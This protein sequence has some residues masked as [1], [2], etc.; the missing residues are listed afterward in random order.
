M[1]SD[2]E[3]E[4]G[5]AK[6]DWFLEHGSIQ[7]ELMKLKKEAL[8]SK[9]EEI[10][11]KEVSNGD[12]SSEAPSGE[13]T[14]NGPV[15][16]GGPGQDPSEQ[17]DGCHPIDRAQSPPHVDRVDDVV[18]EVEGD[19][20]EGRA[21]RL[22]SGKIP[23]APN[24]SQKI[25]SVI[26][27]ENK[28]KRRKYEMERNSREKVASAEE[29][30]SPPKEAPDVTVTP[31][32]PAPE[33]VTVSSLDKDGPSTVPSEVQG[34]A[35]AGP[36]E[37]APR[38][39]PDVPVH[40]TAQVRTDLDIDIGREAKVEGPMS[41]QNVPAPPK[42]EEMSPANGATHGQGIDGQ[43]A[44]QPI[45][46][47]EQPIPDA[48]VPMEGRIEMSSPLQDEG[49]AMDRPDDRND[50][51]TEG[52]GSPF[53]TNGEWSEPGRNSKEWLEVTKGP[54]RP[55][56][57]EEKASSPFGRILGLFKRKGK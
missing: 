38:Y 35:A 50:K 23:T 16:R 54:K 7:A 46:D 27:L 24:L 39:V 44:S 18:N 53:R 1:M 36:D 34:I 4:R 30:A 33:P 32:L 2:N 45:P 51:G 13:G 15:Q 17:K 42:V 52:T 28:L 55:A 40:D 57:R 12:P 29:S 10:G 9:A 6:Q 11:K 48:E 41:D 22:P 8:R 19:G 47:A 49:A 3:G 21:P 37:N 25:A 5:R 14:D 20:S 31:T 43:L 26:Q 56:K